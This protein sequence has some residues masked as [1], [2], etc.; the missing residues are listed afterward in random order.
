MSSVVG[1]A[2]L[3]RE[4]IASVLMKNEAGTL[5]CLEASF[6]ADDHTSDPWSF[7]VKVLGTKGGARYSYNDWVSNDAAQ[8]HSHT[9]TAYPETIAAA[10]E[11][12]LRCVA[13]ETGATQPLST[14]QDAIAA[15]RIV[16]AAERSAAEGV[17]V[18]L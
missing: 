16:E 18:A 12:F 17:H 7:Y 15:Q 14:M 4:N 11:Y 13:D 5:A 2:A 10:S 8:V 9:Y 1:D 3:E 6:A